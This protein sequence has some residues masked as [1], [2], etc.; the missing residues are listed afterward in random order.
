MK[1]LIQ[2]WLGITKIQGKLDRFPTKTRMK[3]LEDDLNYRWNIVRES[4]LLDGKQNLGIEKLNW[5]L[6]KVEDKLELNKK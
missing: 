5:R 2:K 3:F 6:N 4:G 1:K